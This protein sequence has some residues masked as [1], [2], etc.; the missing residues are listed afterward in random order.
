M[1]NATPGGGVRHACAVNE[2]ALQGQRDRVVALRALRHEDIG[3]YLA[4]F[5]DDPGLAVALGTDA[6]TAE[7]LARRVDATPQAG[8]TVHAAAIADAATDAFAGVAMMHHLEAE[9]ARGEVGFWVVPG[10]RRRGLAEHAVGLLIGWAFA[11]LGL[12]RIELTT[13][14]ENG[15]AAALAGKLGF[16]REGVLRSRDVEFGRR[17][18]IVWFGLL[19]DEW[20]WRP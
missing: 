15:A 5:A 14:P 8:A 20:A 3:P 1:T 18:D 11:E 2:R 4:A 7:G 6:P 17:V 12:E 13:T 16:T 10:A 9:H 19:R